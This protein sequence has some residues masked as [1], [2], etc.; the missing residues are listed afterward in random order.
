V[1]LCPAKTPSSSWRLSEVGKDV[2]VLRGAS[3]L[4]QRIFWRK[5]VWWTFRRSNI[6]ELLRLP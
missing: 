1:N 5:L 3:K 6:I 2:Q 4:W